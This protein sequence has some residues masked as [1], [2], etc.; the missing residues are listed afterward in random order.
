MNKIT[1]IGVPN[2]PITFTINPGTETAVFGSN[3]TT[4]NPLGYARVTV[5]PTLN[6]SGTFTVSVNA[7][8][9]LSGTLTDIGNA[10][11]DTNG[12]NLVEPFV[13]S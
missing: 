1:G 10:T 13:I 9:Y 11:N 5:R 6:R 12:Q 7:P 2:A 3:T 8:L 4:T